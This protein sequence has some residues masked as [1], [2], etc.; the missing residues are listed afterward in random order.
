[1][2][3]K[4]YPIEVD[5]RL[6]EEQKGPYMIEWWTQA[7]QLLIDQKINKDDVAAM[8]AETPVNIREGLKE[9]IENCKEKKVPFL[10]FSAGVKSNYYLLLFLF[11]FFFE[12]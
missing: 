5:N 10:V 6:T 3:D 7:H 1:L 12:K 8:V 11:E 4:Y 2:V 9:L